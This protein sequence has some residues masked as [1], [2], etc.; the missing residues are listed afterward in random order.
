[1]KLQLELIGSAM[2]LLALVHLA[3]PR[4]F[5][6]KESL[7]GQ[8]L[9]HRQVVKVHTFFIALTVFL[10]GLLCLTSAR[11]L[12]DT[13]LGRRIALGLAFFWGCRLL[14]QLFGYSTKLWRGKPFETAVHVAAT[15]AWVWFTAV[16]AWVAAA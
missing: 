15:L 6:W 2:I 12:V 13:V 7:A 11:L 10:M 3:F 4:Y 8:T 16:F 14:I 1:M 9:L 5:A